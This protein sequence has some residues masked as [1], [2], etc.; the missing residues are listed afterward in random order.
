MLLMTELKS[1]I[2]KVLRWWN[3]DKGMLH[4]R[5]RP[6]VTFKT[7][8]FKWRW[9]VFVMKS[10]HSIFFLQE[11]ID[12]VQLD[13]F[14]T[15]W[16]AGEILVNLKCVRDITVQLSEVNFEPRMLNVQMNRNGKTVENLIYNFKGQYVVCEF[17]YF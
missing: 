14:K 3:R 16:T 11:A 9:S 7:N 15:D 4:V 8:A 13:N 5:E 12:K 17:L 2:S 1:P 10:G 6:E